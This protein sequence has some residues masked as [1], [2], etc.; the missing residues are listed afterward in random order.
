MQVDVNGDEV[1]IQLDIKKEG[2]DLQDEIHES[3]ERMDSILLDLASILRKAK[4]DA[5]NEFRQP[6]GAWEPGA[7]HPRME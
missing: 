3:A 6:P 5:A 4:Y 2:D 7:T 1:T